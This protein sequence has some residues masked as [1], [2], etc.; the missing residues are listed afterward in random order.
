MFQACNI[1]PFILFI[2]AILKFRC[3]LSDAAKYRKVYELK[4]EMML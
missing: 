4:S 1:F 3:S 2:A